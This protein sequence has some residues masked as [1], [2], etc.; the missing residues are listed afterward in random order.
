MTQTNLLTPHAK[1][2]SAL[3]RCLHIHPDHPERPARLGAMAMLAYMSW[4]EQ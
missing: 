4:G 2:A 3:R 1:Y